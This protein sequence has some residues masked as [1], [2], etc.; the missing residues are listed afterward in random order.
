MASVGLTKYTPFLYFI[1][2]TLGSA[3]FLLLLTSFVALTVE[4][5]V[6]RSCPVGLFYND[7]TDSCVSSCF[8][9]YGDWD[10]GRCMQG[11]IFIFNCLSRVSHCIHIVFVHPYSIERFCFTFVEYSNYNQ[12]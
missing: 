11:I 3:F 7:T 6:D 12:K 8:P 10:T 2:M 9:N 1:R 5:C 4:T